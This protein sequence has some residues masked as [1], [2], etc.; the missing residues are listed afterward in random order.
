VRKALESAEVD[1]EASMATTLRKLGN[2]DSIPK[3]E[4]MQLVGIVTVAPLE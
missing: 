3:K 1:E 2:I 4:L